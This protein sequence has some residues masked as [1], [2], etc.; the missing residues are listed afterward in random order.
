MTTTT[1]SIIVIPGKVHKDIKPTSSSMLQDQSS[2][3]DNLKNQQNQQQRSPGR[4][5]TVEQLD[6]LT[7]E[8]QQTNQHHDKRV[9]RCLSN[10]FASAEADSGTSGSNTMTLLSPDAA[11]AR[12][13]SLKHMF[14]PPA[15]SQPPLPSLRSPSS[16]LKSDS[17]SLQTPS[18]SR[19]LQP[20]PSQMVLPQHPYHHGHDGSSSRRMSIF[21]GCRLDRSTTTHVPLRRSGKSRAA[22]KPL[23]DDG[24]TVASSGNTNEKVKGVHFESTVQVVRIP[25]HKDY[26]TSLKR[27]LWGSLKDIKQNAMRNTTEYIFDACQWRNATEEQDMYFD[28]QSG[29]YIHPVHIQRYYAAM[30]KKSKLKQEQKAEHE[31]QQHEEEIKESKE[32]SPANSTLPYKKRKH[33]A[34]TTSNTPT[35][36]SKHLRCCTPSP[37]RRL[38]DVLEEEEEQYE[39]CDE[40]PQ[41]P[42]CPPSPKRLRIASPTTYSNYYY[43][44]STEPQSLSPV[45]WQYPSFTASDMPCSGQAAAC[46]VLPTPQSPTAKQA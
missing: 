44:Y 13:S 19:M 17:S 18:A 46:T 25:S 36:S 45:Y 16:S 40:R 11:R 27:T 35:S 22:R 24:N 4:F 37:I 29:K 33:A 28:Q 38:D 5:R 7:S 23:P 39:R 43:S 21:F 34:T 31:Q 15:S 6:H 14:L 20:R 32:S 41:L 26:T 8:R 3:S 2:S 10:T 42:P 12:R 30:M 1:T 9:F